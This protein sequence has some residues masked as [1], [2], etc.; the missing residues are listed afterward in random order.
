MVQYFAVFLI[1]CISDGSLGTTTSPQQQ[2][3]EEIKD[4][5]EVWNN[6]PVLVDIPWRVALRKKK[7]KKMH[8]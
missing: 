7:K 5:C 4:L 8:E 3:S 2:K 6:Y 1:L